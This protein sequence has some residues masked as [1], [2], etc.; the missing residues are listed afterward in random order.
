M[1]VVE[2]EPA[3]GQAVARILPA[4]GYHACPPTTAPRPSTLYA[5]H[6]CDLLLTDVIMPEMS[7]PQ[8]AEPCWTRHPGLPVLYMSGYSDGLL[9][10]DHILDD[11]IAFIEKPFTSAGLLTRV[12]DLAAAANRAAPSPEHPAP[13]GTRP[14]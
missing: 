4:G 6:G 12:G 1:L 7:G 11:E 5:E 13:A 2:D 9:G 8:L 3:L 10:H 14:G